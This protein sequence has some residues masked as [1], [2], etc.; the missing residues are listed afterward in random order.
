MSY[1]HTPSK[2][3][4]SLLVLGLLGSSVINSA[5]EPFLYVATISGYPNYVSNFTVIDTETKKVVQ[6]IPVSVQP[7]VFALQTPMVVSPDGKA[8][9]FI[10]EQSLADSTISALN[11]GTN[12]IGKPISVK[13]I[14]L[15]LATSPN[16][17]KVYVNHTYEH[18]GCGYGPCSFDFTTIDVRTRKVSVIPLPSLSAGFAISPDG[19]RAYVFDF[20]DGPHDTIHV[21]DLTRNQIVKPLVLRNAVFQGIAFGPDGEHLYVT[22]LPLGLLVVNI[23]SQMVEKTI[24]GVYG[25]IVITP[26]GKLAYTFGFMPVSI[27]DLKTNEIIASLPMNLYGGAVNPDGKSIYFLAY[28]EQYFSNSVSIM[29]TKSQKIVG[30]IPVARL[31]RLNRHRG[32]KTWLN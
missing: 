10:S 22:A 21:I 2:A 28:G 5:A 24:P 18:G 17:D 19:K 26:D 31:W 23:R 9:Y 3:A 11:T 1:L 4:L 8:V 6:T 7:I 14:A 32:R 25:E 15:S 30:S 29:D 16:G 13:R 12:K 20:P 27:V